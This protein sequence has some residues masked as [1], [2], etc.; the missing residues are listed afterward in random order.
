MAFDATN[1]SLIGGSGAGKLWMYQT[2]DAAAGV[3]TAGYFNDYVS[4]LNVHDVI[5][6]AVGIGGTLSRGLVVVVSND[7]TTVDVSDIDA[8]VWDVTDSD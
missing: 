8:N 3:D 6:F 4:D 2:T 5:L 1:M 7:G